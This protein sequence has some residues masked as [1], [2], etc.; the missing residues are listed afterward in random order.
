LKYTL[1]DKDDFLPQ[2]FVLPPK[3]DI[4]DILARIPNLNGLWSR[5]YSV[6][7]EFEDNRRDIFMNLY[8]GANDIKMIAQAQL[9]GF[10]PQIP[11]DYDP[12]KYAGSLHNIT[13][14]DSE[15]ELH[16]NITK[17]RTLSS[18]VLYCRIIIILVPDSIISNTFK[19]NLLSLEL[20]SE[21]HCCS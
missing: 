15:T 20:Y 17:V 16:T 5:V 13:D 4:D 9:V 3:P 2:F 11:D 19:F 8:Y 10:R 1:T 18:N 14:V 6:Y 7:D 12:P 21:I